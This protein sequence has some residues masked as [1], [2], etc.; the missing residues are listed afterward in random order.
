MNNKKSVIWRLVAGV[1]FVGLLGVPARAG[2][3]SPS[4]AHYGLNIIGV[5]NPKNSSLTSSDRRTIFVGLGTK[6]NAVSSSIYLTQGDFKVCDG[7]GF[8]TAYDCSGSSLGK[9]GAV[10][11]LPCNTYVNGSGVDAVEG[12][13]SGNSAAYEVYARALGKQGGSASITTCATETYGTTSTT[14]DEVYCSMENTV[15]VRSNGKQSFNNV[16]DSLT[17]MVV[18][19]GDISSKT[20]V[21]TRTALFSGDLVDWY[22][23]YDNKGLKLAQLRFYLQ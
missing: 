13:E 3:G 17:S 11:Q 5:T 14:D 18:C 19:E 7:N 23:Q 15:L 1:A 16:T 22:W 9:R 8:D 4:G 2:S 20:S 6:T 10:F 21:C 12:C